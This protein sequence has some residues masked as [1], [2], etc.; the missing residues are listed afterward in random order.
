[1]RVLAGRSAIQRHVLDQTLG[2]DGRHGHAVTQDGIA[3]SKV[4][5]K[6]DDARRQR[7]LA[8][9]VADHPVAMGMPSHAEAV[10]DQG[11]ARHGVYDRLLVA[12]VRGGF[13][14]CREYGSAQYAGKSGLQHPAQL[15]R[16]TDAPAQKH[17]AFVDA[18]AGGLIQRLLARDLAQ[19]M[20]AGLGRLQY[21][22]ARAGIEPRF[23][24]VP[25]PPLRAIFHPCRQGPQ[26]G[27]SR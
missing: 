8:T 2:L 22:K 9:G 17:H 10:G 25:G 16:V 19:V 24:L 3:F 12:R 11:V 6:T 7:S 5:R 20:T 18:K 1:M 15:R 14:G 23:A 27:R 4:V 21:A 26:H 13:P